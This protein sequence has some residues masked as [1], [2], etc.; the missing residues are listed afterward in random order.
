MILE[1]PVTKSKGIVQVDTDKIPENVYIEAVRL[2]M[3]E[4]VNRGMAKIT[5]AAYN[6]ADAKKAGY[7]NLEANMRADAQKK[8]EAN[9][10]DVLV[11]KIRFS[12]GAKAKKAS[13]VVLNEARRLARA[14]VK[15]LIKANGGK[16]SHFE[17]KEITAAA[18]ALLD[19]AQGPD[20]LSK[21]E[22]NIKER[23]SV[24]VEGVNIMD[25]VKASPALIA[26]AE[27]R[28]ADKKASAP[29]S[30]TQAGRTATRAKPAPQASA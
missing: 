29:L 20:I 5:K 19:S 12:A 4:L 1:V 6:D 9:A 22:A 28:A 7:E 2:G 14:I 27:K 25:L 23:E 10:A 16:I 24:K 13:G 17:A 11:G 30:K 26:K 21:A 8:A 15:D 18:N 3:K